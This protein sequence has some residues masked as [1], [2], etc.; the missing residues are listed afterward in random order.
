MNT[1]QQVKLF[2]KKVTRNEKVVRPEE[3]KEEKRRIIEDHH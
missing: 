3:T 2:M 1:K